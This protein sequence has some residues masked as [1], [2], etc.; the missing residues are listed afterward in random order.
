MSA[1]ATTA[2]QRLRR[3]GA[4]M[5]WPRGE[6]RTTAS[7]TPSAIDGW[8]VKSSRTGKGLSKNSGRAIGSATWFATRSPINDQVAPARAE[9]DEDRRPEKIELLLARER[10]RVSEG[11]RPVGGPVRRV[12]EVVGQVGE[13]PLPEGRVAPGVEPGRDE[14]RQNREVEREDPERAPRKELRERD[15][16]E[17]RALAQEQ[18]RDQESAD[19]EE[20]GHALG[21][22]IEKMPPAAGFAGVVPDHSEDADGAQAVE[23]AELAAREKLRVRCV[24][25]DCGHGRAIIAGFVHRTLAVWSIPSIMVIS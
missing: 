1:N 10:P 5:A 8:T 4:R 12:G 14:Q 18:R 16:A 23:R 22:A 9:E 13:E 7:R 15:R 21:A 19:R 17:A 25:G 24:E 3:A 6:S 20:E 2:A 11:R